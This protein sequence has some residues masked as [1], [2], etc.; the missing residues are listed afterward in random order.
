VYCARTWLSAKGVRVHCKST[1]W[2]LRTSELWFIPV[3]GHRPSRISC[4]CLI[5]AKSAWVKRCE[6]SLYLWTQLQQLLRWRHPTVIRCTWRGGD[7]GVADDT[8]W[9][10]CIALVQTSARCVSDAGCRRVTDT[11]M[12]FSLVDV[13]AF[14]RSTDPLQHRSWRTTTWR[15]K[16]MHY[17]T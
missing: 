15:S 17:M 2:I 12:K 10:R 8:A 6:H 9:R 16:L 5:T 3:Y 7:G 11:E 4:E 1:R 13:S 14:V